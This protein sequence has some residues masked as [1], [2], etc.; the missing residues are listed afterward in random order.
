MPK[1]FRCVSSPKSTT[2]PRAE[3]G[4]AG[5]AALDI[6]QKLRCFRQFLTRWARRIHSRFD[7][8]FDTDLNRRAPGI[9]YRHPSLVV[10]PK[11]GSRGEKKR[12]LL[13]SP[14]C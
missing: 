4:S 10:T 11:S 2:A 1:G 3:K 9:I 6:D 14:T 8:N 12:P 5:Q 7:C 13:L